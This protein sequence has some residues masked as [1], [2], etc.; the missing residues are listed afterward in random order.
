MALLPMQPPILCGPSFYLG[1]K[2]GGGKAAG[3][4]VLTTYHHVVPSLRI[5]GYIPL[6]HLYALTVWTGTTLLF[7]FAYTMYVSVTCGHF[8]PTSISVG[9]HFYLNQGKLMYLGKF[10]VFIF[11][12]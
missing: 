9:I 5:S 12:C 2:G 10:L 3:V 4:M 7:N 11:L 1:V 8:V 6:L